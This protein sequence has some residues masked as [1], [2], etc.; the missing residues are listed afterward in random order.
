MLSQ[1]EPGAMFPVLF[2]CKNISTLTEQ[3]FPWAKFFRRAERSV[4]TLA[5]YTKFS[6]AKIFAATFSRQLMENINGLIKFLR[7]AL[8]AQIYFS[9]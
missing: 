7:Q 9:F 6:C 2:C 3:L 4:R 8:L 5:S 1:K